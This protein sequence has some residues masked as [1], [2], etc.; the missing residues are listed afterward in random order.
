MDISL[1]PYIFSPLETAAARILKHVSLLP[2]DVFLEDMYLM[3]EMLG[4][5]AE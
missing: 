4:R 1:F 2:E 5:A 3:V